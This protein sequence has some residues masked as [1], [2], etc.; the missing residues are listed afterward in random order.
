MIFIETAHSRKFLGTLQLAACEA[1]LPADSGFQGQAA[2]GP[3]LPF[4]AET[5]RRVLARIR[6]SLSEHPR[7][8]RLAYI[9][10]SLEEEF[11]RS[12]WLVRTGIREDRLFDLHRASYWTNRSE[13]LLRAQG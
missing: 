10:P 1:V 12:G 8:V 11:E 3:E 5:M 13:S 6:A 9:H 7:Q 2:V 4:G